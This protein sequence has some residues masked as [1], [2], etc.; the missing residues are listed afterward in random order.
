MAAAASNSNTYKIGRTYLTQLL[1]DFKV[2]VRKERE[3][4]IIDIFKVIDFKCGIAGTDSNYFYPVFQLRV[5]FNSLV[6]F[7]DRRCFPLA[8]GTVHAKY[9]NN[10]NI[11]SDFRYFELLVTFQ[12]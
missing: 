7:I 4:D 6:Y 12:T 10:H 1:V 2:T 8:M 11:G 5:T 9:L 3:R